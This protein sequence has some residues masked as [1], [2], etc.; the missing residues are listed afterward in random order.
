MGCNAW[1]HHPDCDCG[2]GGDTSA[3]RIYASVES[4]RVFPWARGAA[5]NYYSYVNPNA[6]CPIC[7]ER[8]FF[9][10]SPYGGR[11][12][13]DEL[14]PPWPK[15]PCTNTT[16]ARVY[17]PKPAPLSAPPIVQPQWARNGW[18]PIS[19]VDINK[20]DGGN[21][22]TGILLNDGKKISL[23]IEDYLVI[24]VNTPVLIKK[25][26]SMLGFYKVSLI[27]HDPQLEENMSITGNAYPY[28]I[29]S[30]MMRHWKAGLQ[31]NV[32]SQNMIGMYLSFYFKNFTHNLF[33]ISG[34][35]PDWNAALFWFEK[36]AKSGCW[37]ANNNLGVMYLDG[38]GVPKNPKRAFDYLM[39]ASNKLN[40]ITLSNLERC[41]RNGEGCDS[42]SDMADFIAEL[43][44]TL[45]S[46]TTG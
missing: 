25:V 46:D 7:R 36:A 8:V 9:Y 3:Y 32:E 40:P 15:H 43:K 1:N 5:L 4:V 18:E 11:V 38:H 34:F 21:A 44:A 20:F 13:F 31:G 29:N 6:L 45:E 2:W 12:Y 10:Q 16:Y 26:H 41:Y 30:S 35:R 24:D 42:D 22:I 33:D 39:R 28:C 23:G 17:D 19:I 14:G 37:E 27:M